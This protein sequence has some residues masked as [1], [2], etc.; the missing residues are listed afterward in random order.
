MKFH[1]Y[2]EIE[3]AIREDL[4]KL[5]SHFSGNFIQENGLRIFQLERDDLK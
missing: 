2:R 4:I 3:D 5:L 1:K